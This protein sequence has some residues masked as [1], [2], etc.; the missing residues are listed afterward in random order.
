[1]GWSEVWKMEQTLG[2]SLEYQ[3][4]GLLIF[5]MSF[6]WGRKEV[7]REGEVWRVNTS[8]LPQQMAPVPKGLAGR[9]SRWN[10][11]NVPKSSVCSAK[12]KKRPVLEQ[13][14]GE[15]EQ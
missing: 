13:L 12:K 9:W 3:F 6:S 7:G 10:A 14:L 1:M 5:K 4:Q 15:A 8:D 2:F 11:L